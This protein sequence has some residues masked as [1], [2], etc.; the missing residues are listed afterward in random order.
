LRVEEHDKGQSERA[1]RED[2][3]RFGKE[4]YLHGFLRMQFVDRV[5]TP[6]GRLCSRIHRLHRL[7]Y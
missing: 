1:E 5:R 2:Q 3:Q 4:L 7:I 6:I